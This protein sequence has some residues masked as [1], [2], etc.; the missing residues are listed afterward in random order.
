[1][2]NIQVLSHDFGQFAS[3]CLFTPQGA[4]ARNFQGEYGVIQL[5]Q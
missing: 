3:G 5:E 4:L 1:M 2:S